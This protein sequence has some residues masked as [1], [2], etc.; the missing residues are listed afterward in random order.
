M[1]SKLL[2]NLTR[3]LFVPK[4]LQ[5][6]SPTYW[7][8]LLMKLIS[9]WKNSCRFELKVKLPTTDYC[10]TLQIRH[11]LNAIERMLE[12]QWYSNW[13]L[14]LE[15]LKLIFRVIHSPTLSIAMEV[16]RRNYAVSRNSIV[17]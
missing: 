5:K 17:I 1:E 9:T 10:R 12:Q 7:I 11:K 2:E 4:Y 15:M 8:C 13:N 6:K 16:L 3:F 14:E